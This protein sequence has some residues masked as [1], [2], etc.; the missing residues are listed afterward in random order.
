[1]ADPFSIVAGTV[2]LLDVC[3][4]V[5]SYLSKVKA[6]A[7]KI[8]QDL[9]TLSNEVNALITVNKSIQALWDANK[10]PPPGIP[11]SDAERI[12]GLWQDINLALRGCRGVMDNLSNLVEEIIGKGGPSVQGRRDGIKKVLRK[13]SKSEEILEIRH[14]LSSHQGS[15]QL[16]LSA[17]N[18]CYTR[19]SQRSNGSTLGHLNDNVESWGFKL[20]H[21]LAAIRARMAADGDTKAKGS[22]I[23]N[24][25]AVASQ[26]QLNK[27]FQLPRAVSS[28]FTGRDDLL[29]DLKRLIFDASS[30]VDSK[31]IQKRFVIYGLGGSGKTEFCCKFAQ[32]NQ[33]SFWGVF[34]INA[35][36][37]QTVKHT[38]SSIAQTAGRAANERAGKDWL[39]TLAH[40]WLLIIDNADDRNT[41]LEELFPEG[42]MGVILI[43]TRNP[44][45]RL[46][47]TVG[48]GSYHFER[49]G[50]AEA[51]D[52]LLRAAYEPA[53]WSVA[54]RKS[55]TKITKHLGYLALALIQAGKA[56]A[57]HIATLGNYLEVYDRSWQRIRRSRRRSSEKGGQ[58]NII[59]M[60]VYSS[61]EIIFRGLEATDS[62]P[63]Q[64]AVELIKMFSFLSWEDLRIDVLTTSVE[65]PRLQLEDDKREAEKAANE[66]TTKGTKLMQTFKG[67][68]VWVYLSLQTDRTD[69]ILPK[70]LRDNEGDLFDEDRL[71]DALDQLTQ[72][73]LISYQE[74]T[75][76]YSM[77]PLIHTWVRERPQMSTSEQAL[78]CQAAST[79]LSRSILLPPL[80]TT[81]SAE[82]L[83]RHL[84]PHINHVLDFQARIQARILENL[85]TRRYFWPATKTKFGRMQALESAKFSLIY[86]QNGY[87]AE[88]ETLQVKVKDFVCARLGMEHAA[89]RRITLFLAGTYHLQ[90]RTNKAAELQTEVFEA[91]QKHLGADHP[92]TLKVMDTLGALR[93]FQGR[94]SEARELLEKAIDGMTRTLGPEHEDTILAMD[95]LGRVLVRYFKYAEARECHLKA[96]SILTKSR[97]PT[98]E[99]TL[100]AKESLALVYLDI[101]GEA[102]GK[103]DNPNTD[104]ALSQ[105]HTLI[106]E[107]LLSR[108]Q[109]LGDEH[110]LTLLAICNL[111][112]ITSAS[113]DHIEAERLMRGAAALPTAERN[114]GPNHIG[115]LMGW[116]HLANFLARQERFLEAELIFKDVLQRQRYEASAR[117]DGEH[118]ERILG[119]WYLLKCYENQGKFDQAVD[120]CED[121]FDALSVIG[122]KRL[123]LLHPFAKRVGERREELVLLRNNYNRSKTPVLESAVT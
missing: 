92:E 100:T 62:T 93:C 65:H 88:G 35:S 7:G 10:D 76:S 46:H 67:W 41:P 45:N 39:A 96:I 70:V 51:N 25:A 80:D 104:A 2:S 64:D 28:I 119:M 68:A 122:G 31:H 115:T 121:I 6:G 59:N 55:A 27:H 3:W 84:L 106:N 97:G 37:P 111:A 117:D 19:S 23:P 77:H 72:L 112:R 50:E 47:G 14:Q 107:V 75:E 17:L 57:K 98:D 24:A 105:A 32:D 5:G 83:R 89:A 110:P 71:M 56:I 13:Q 18:L 73:S 81:D 94:F 53:P 4:R 29:T 114:L 123:G 44:L 36:S 87:F 78:W 16:T 95:N 118:P 52:L 30:S 63:T 40:P 38:Y 85:K 49:L 79:T 58:D 90:A 103:V 21:E 34:H 82:L 108:Q 120:L 86:V 69:P 109:K 43:T 48:S 101:G 26:F 99:K 9:A 15:L 1:M 20:Q 11:R 74:A 102:L 42:D 8:E 22:T 91:C 116:T 54:V 66:T 33:Q 61:Y 12:E 113:G 60:N